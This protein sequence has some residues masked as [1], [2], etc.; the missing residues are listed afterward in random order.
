MNTD[1]ERIAKSDLVSSRNLGTNSDTWRFVSTLAAKAQKGHRTPTDGLPT[2]QAT[3]TQNPSLTD[4]EMTYTHRL[5]NGTAVFHLE[6]SLL[7]DKDR[8]AIADDFNVY[9]DEGSK[10]FLIDL[11]KLSH[12]NSTG[13]G[14]FIS[15]YT[16]V[17]SRSGDLM[18]V[19]PSSHISNLLSITKLDTIFKVVASVE[20]GLQR[21][22]Q[23]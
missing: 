10:F 18:L 2:M 13:L 17:K 14:V 20:E 19:N 15:L 9:L 16:K 22:Q 4:Q 6:G 8:Q 7:S 21:L 5:E 3:D 12:I 1:S 23:A 11:S